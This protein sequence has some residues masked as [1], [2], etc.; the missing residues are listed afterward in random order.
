MVVMQFQSFALEPIVHELR[1]LEEQI[2]SGDDFP[3]CVDAQL[4]FQGDEPV[5]NLR[6]PSALPG[7]IDVYDFHSPEMF[8]ELL[9]MMDDV[10]ADDLS[11]LFKQCHDL[12]PPFSHV[13]GED[14]MKFFPEFAQ[15]REIRIDFCNAQSKLLMFFAI[16]HEPRGKIIPS[17]G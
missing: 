5:K 8:P 1:A 11:I 10:L 4:P 15:C 16:T 2:G 9:E 12:P 13:Y 14:S 17:L 7:G 3:L 6:N